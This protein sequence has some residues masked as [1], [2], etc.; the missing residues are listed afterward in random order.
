MEYGTVLNLLRLKANSLTNTAKR[1]SLD[2]M[3]KAYERAYK[4]TSF[5]LS[6]IQTTAKGY[7]NLGIL[8]ELI[9]KSYYGFSGISG[10]NGYD[11]ELN[12]I[13]Y[14]IKTLAVAQ[15]HELTQPCDIIVLVCTSSRKGVYRITKEHS[16]NL[17]NTR[18]S[19]AA[20]K[21]Y[22]RKDKE[23]SKYLGL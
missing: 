2:Y 5:N 19:L 21:K 23:L 16:K 12:N 4:Q 14:E 9:I 3:I 7:I 17:L 15:P 20:I 1:I 13:K 11:M 22:G 18:I 8:G 10:S 6:D